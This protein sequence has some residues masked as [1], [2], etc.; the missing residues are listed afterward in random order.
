MDCTDLRA[1]LSGFVDGELDPP[2]RH[3]AERHLVECA[4]CR[5]RV[6]RT[7][8]LDVL[9]R[10]AA[11]RWGREEPLPPPIIERVLARTIADVGALRR[12]RRWAMVGWLAAAAGVALAATAWWAAERRP[13]SDLPPSDRVNGLTGELASGVSGHAGGARPTTDGSS[14]GLRLDPRVEPG[15]RPPVS[16]E[17]LPRSTQDSPR[18]VA[19]EDPARTAPPL[20]AT[21]HE[22]MVTLALHGPPSWLTLVPT[23]G[24]SDL[25]WQELED[26][27]GNELLAEDVQDG[28]DTLIATAQLL[29]HFHRVRF[30]SPKCLSELRARIEYDRLLD[31][32]DQ[33]DLLL[34]SVEG[35][36][37]IRAASAMLLRLQHLSDDLEDLREMQRD[38][39]RIP[40][41][42]RLEQLAEALE[43]KTQA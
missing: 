29:R 2:R 12:A 16:P 19:A 37:S 24:A 9:L 18:R 5:A 35:H 34:G 10:E 27:R 41:A 1:I 32:L 39:C 6:A 4:E 30:A 17:R 23:N 40:L 13:Q 21:P 22:H 15:P 28:V 31:R 8:S 43:V 11:S 42:R 33:A 14:P 3:E 38:L 26:L 25:P 7:E 36:E 20:A